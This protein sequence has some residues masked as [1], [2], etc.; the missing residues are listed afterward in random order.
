MGVMD[1]MCSGRKDIWWQAPETAVM[2]R[3]RVIAQM[4]NMGTFEDVHVLRYMIELHIQ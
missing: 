3:H 1:L 4:M 2:D